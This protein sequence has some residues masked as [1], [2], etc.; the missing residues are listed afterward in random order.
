MERKLRITIEQ[1]Q[2]EVLVQDITEGDENTLYP[3]PGM[4]ADAPTPKPAATLAKAPAAPKAAAPAAGGSGG[5]T[6]RLAPMGGVVVQVLVKDGQQVAKGDKVVILEA[7]KQKTEIL[8][9]RA[10]TVK[11]IACKEGDSV[12][13][14]VRLMSIV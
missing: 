14:G 5:E 6:D 4:R 10:G 9:H 12:E 2:Y 11:N 13:I 1:T 7:M 8:A 3:S